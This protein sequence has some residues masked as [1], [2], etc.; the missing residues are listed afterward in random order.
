MLPRSPPTEPRH[1]D[2]TPGMLSLSLSSEN[3]LQSQDQ[4]WGTCH[5]RQTKEVF[6]G[7]KVIGFMRVLLQSLIPYLQSLYLRQQDQ[8]DSDQINN[9]L[10]SKGKER[11]RGKWKRASFA[12]IGE[13]L[14]QAGYMLFK[15][16]ISETGTGEVGQQ[17]QHKVWSQTN[18]GLKLDSVGY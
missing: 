12:Q 16:E 3:P 1:V 17:K 6:S 13:G 18:L 14:L 5:Q 8:L 4:G 2:S 10:Q 9:V 7:E 15:E 11:E